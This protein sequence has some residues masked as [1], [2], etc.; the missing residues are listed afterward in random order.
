[1]PRWIQRTVLAV[2]VVAAFGLH[3]VVSWG[4]ALSVVMAVGVAGSFMSLGRLRL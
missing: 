3:Y 1:M 2:A 4:W